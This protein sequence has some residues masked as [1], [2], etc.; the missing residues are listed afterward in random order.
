MIRDASFVAIF[1]LS[2]SYVIEPEG[3]AHRFFGCPRAF[4]RCALG[5]DLS[6]QYR[7]ADGTTLFRTYSPVLHPFC[8]LGARLLYRIA[9]RAAHG[10]VEEQDPEHHPECAGGE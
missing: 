2:F 6:A 8:R 7:R 10:G 4:C 5:G 9:L 1:L 3:N